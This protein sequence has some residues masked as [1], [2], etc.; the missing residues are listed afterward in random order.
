MTAKE[1][2]WSLGVAV[3]GEKGRSHLGKLVATYGEA[4]V[5]EAAAEAVREKPGEPKAWLTAACE[6]RAKSR[7][8]PKADGDQALLDRDPRPQWVIDAGFPD[9]WQAESS[10]CGPGNFRKFAG[11]KR[12]TA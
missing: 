9:I 3:L 7:S 5:A 6:A 12:V 11:G 10:G 8:A 1:L 4:V 2:A